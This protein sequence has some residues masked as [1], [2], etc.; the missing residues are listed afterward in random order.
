MGP[1]KPF[2]Q[3]GMPGQAGGGYPMAAQKPASPMFRMPGQA[4]GQYWQPPAQM[5]QQAQDPLVRAMMARPSI[6]RGGR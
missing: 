2:Q 5:A 3:F 1:N 6:A 4:G